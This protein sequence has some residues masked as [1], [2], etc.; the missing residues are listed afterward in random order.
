MSPRNKTINRRTIIV[1][2]AGILVVS[3]S[4][5]W[6]QKT[7]PYHLL[8]VEP[9]VLY[10]SGALKPHNL[11][12]VVDQYGIRTIVS[13]RH[14]WEEDPQPD[15]Y[16]QEKEF[17]AR[18]GLT[19]VHIPM[20]GNSP[21]TD[22]QLAQWLV[23]LD[24]PKNYP[25]LVHCSQGAIRTGIMTAIY[26]ME[27]RQKDN[28]KTLKELNTFGHDLDVPKRKRMCEYIL[29]Y[30]PRWKQQEDLTK[31]NSGESNHERP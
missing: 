20:R 9:G 26:E 23:L 14:R 19:F 18:N 4:L 15:W 28:Q 21:P 30:V 31:S 8:T 13:L 3:G 11:K 1:F 2:V 12:N 22:E 17:C 24:N 25:I 29:N 5:F 6:H 27:Y 10:R 16:N 7:K